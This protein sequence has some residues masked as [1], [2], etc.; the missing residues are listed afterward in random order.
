MKTCQLQFVGML[1]GSVDNKGVR[2]VNNEPIEL[3]DFYH[4]DYV[5]IEH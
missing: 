3:T 1:L 5:K 4:V 2:P